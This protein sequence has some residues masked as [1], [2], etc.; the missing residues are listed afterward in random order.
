MQSRDGRS[1]RKVTDLKGDGLNGAFRAK[2]I[3]FTVVKVELQT[4]LPFTILKLKL[5]PPSHSTH[6]SS[7]FPSYQTTS[8][9]E[10]V[11][12]KYLISFTTQTK[13]CLL[14]NGSCAFQ[15]SR[16]VTKCFLPSRILSPHRTFLTRRETFTYG[17][18]FTPLVFRPVFPNLFC[19]MPHL[20]FFKFAMPPDVRH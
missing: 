20:R 18:Q 4:F 7:I 12:P 9:G 13:I 16:Q 17:S 5:F 3:R 11:K 19:S 14:L 2:G 10:M 15:V 6:D 8:S 1:Q